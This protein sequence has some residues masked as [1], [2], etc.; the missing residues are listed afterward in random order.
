[1]SVHE[2]CVRHL[3]TF[4]PIDRLLSPH[5]FE[6]VEGAWRASL[7]TR[8]AADV[9]ARLAADGAELVAGTPEAFAQTLRSET[10]KWA[11]VA[12]AAGI[13]PE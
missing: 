10:D 2:V 1:M 5:A 6:E 7:T 8:D 13:V 11:R 12:K 3:P 4:V 9:Q